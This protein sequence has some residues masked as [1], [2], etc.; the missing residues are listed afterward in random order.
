M[1]AMTLFALTLASLALASDPRQCYTRYNNT[2]RAKGVPWYVCNNTQINP[3]GASLCCYDDSLCGPDSFCGSTSIGRGPYKYGLYVG[4]CTDGTYSD[5]VCRTTC[6][7]DG[8]TWFQWNETTEVY[9]CCSHNAC[10]GTVTDEAFSATPP[11]EWEPFARVATTTSSPA[12]APTAT[13]IVQ[14][15][16]HVR[17]GRLSTGAQAGIGTA[18]GVAGTGA[19]CA[20]AFLLLKR[21]RLSGTEGDRRSPHV[22][23]L[24]RDLLP[25]GSTKAELNSSGYDRNTRN[26]VSELETE[27]AP[28]EVA[29]V[30]NPRQELGGHPL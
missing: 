26:N 15:T 19:V 7:G 29:C 3:G 1:K 27:R 8:A 18:C 11:D 28:A 17:N 21:R 20:L 12:A 23:S 10:I 14:V 25:D 22:Q 4:G 16:P 2:V 5:P 6:T 24:L 30:E 13:V 9:H